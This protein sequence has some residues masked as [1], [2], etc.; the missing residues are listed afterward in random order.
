VASASVDPGKSDGGVMLHLSL[1][2]VFR[3]RQ[4]TGFAQW[5]EWKHDIEGK[6]DDRY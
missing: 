1:Y 2:G 3:G 4:E 5:H 6:V